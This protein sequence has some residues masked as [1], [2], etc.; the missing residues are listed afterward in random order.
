MSVLIM[1]DAAVLSVYPPT[2][3]DE[4][5]FLI[6]G[7]DSISFMTLY[8]IHSQGPTCLVPI[9]GFSSPS[10]VQN[11]VCVKEELEWPCLLFSIGLFALIFLVYEDVY[12]LVFWC[13][14]RCHGQ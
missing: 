2:S 13:A 12:I 14:R 10:P 8:T 9:T 5:I 7:T 6:Q 1:L 11:L 3:L 4:K